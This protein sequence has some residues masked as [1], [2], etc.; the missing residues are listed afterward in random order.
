M[1]RAFA[2]AL[3]LRYACLS[4]ARLEALSLGLPVISTRCGGIDEYLRDGAGWVGGAN[5]RSLAVALV[6]SADATP[7]RWNNIRQASITLVAKSFAIETRARPAVRR[8]GT[9]RVLPCRSRGSTDR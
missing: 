9:Q 2:L 4:N 6:I 1:G 7:N 5:P 8:D 3:P